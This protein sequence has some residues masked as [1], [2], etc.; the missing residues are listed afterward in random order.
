[1]C[2]GF[3]HGLIGGGEL[4]ALLSL[5]RIEQRTQAIHDQFAAGLVQA[6]GRRLQA[7]SAAR[8]DV[9]GGYQQTLGDIAIQLLEPA[10]VRKGPLLQEPLQLAAVRLN[11][12]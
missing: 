1:M 11:L 5:D 12:P 9:A 7:G 4:L 3:G 8:L 2:D 10:L 6:F